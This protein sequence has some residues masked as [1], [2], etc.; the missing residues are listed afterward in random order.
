MFCIVNFEV[1]IKFTGDSDKEKTSEN[2][3][4]FFGVYCYNFNCFYNSFE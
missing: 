2:D 1:K 4:T 3:G